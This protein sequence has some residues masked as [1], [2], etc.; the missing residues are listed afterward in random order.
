MTAFKPIIP[1]HP[2]IQSKNQASKKGKTEG[3]AKLAP[4]GGE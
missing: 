1:Q 4:T 3:Y 2:Q